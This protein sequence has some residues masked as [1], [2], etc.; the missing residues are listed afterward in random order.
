MFTGIVRERG[1]VL[2][3]ERNGDGA[4]R[5]RI[6]APRTAADTSV[7]DSISVAGCCLTAVA[8]DDG[9]LQFDVVPES[10]SRTTLGALAEGAGVNLEPA[11]RAGDPLGGHY[12]QGHVDDVGP[13]RALERD[14]DGAE[15]WPRAPSPST[16]SPS[17]SRRS[18]TPASRSRSSRT[19]STR[20]RSPGCTRE[21]S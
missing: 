1:R 13:V 21:L 2:S 17:R 15:L 7:G 20:R 18:T 12:V 8:A 16:A 3:A 14:D 10:L 11:L 5:L 9:E 4:L 19:L 6:A